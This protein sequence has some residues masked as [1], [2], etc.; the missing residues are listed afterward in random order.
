MTKER[1]FKHLFGHLPADEAGSIRISLM[2]A[3]ALETMAA[4]EEAERLQEKKKE[5]KSVSLENK[6]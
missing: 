2:I 5:I 1:T 4:R 6:K 3:D